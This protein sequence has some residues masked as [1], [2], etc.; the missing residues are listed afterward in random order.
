MPVTR[1]PRDKRKQPAAK[2]RQQPRDTWILEGLGKM[3]F[4]RTGHLGRLFFNSSRSATNKRMR[5]LLDQGLVRAWVNDLTHE[6]VYSL[7]QAGVRI[8]ESSDDE[9]GL[10]TVPR[11]LDGNLDHL[12]AINTVRIALVLGLAEAAGEITFWR[13]DWELRAE[14]RKG[15]VPDALFGVRWDTG[16]EQIFTLEVDN[17]SRSSQ[18]FLKKILRYASVRYQSRTLCG[19]SDF[20]TLV[21]GKDPQWIERYRRSLNHARLGCSIWFTTLEEVLKK[22]VC[23]PIWRPVHDETMHSLRDL[24]MLPYGK[25]GSGHETPVVLGT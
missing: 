4:L 10:F 19:M 12:L 22:G 1:W 7:N 11:R 8:L 13:S 21:V 17:E 25:E 24:T 6:N 20:I 16:E 15:V 18:V 5:K 9:S 23:W 2:V 3:R 14:S